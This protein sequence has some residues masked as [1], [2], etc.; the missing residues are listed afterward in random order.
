MV[1]V[2]CWYVLVVIWRC[3]FEFWLVVVFS[4]VVNF[5]CFVVSE[6]VLDGGLF[7][8]EKLNFLVVG[9]V[10]EFIG[11]VLGFLGLF[12]LVI[13]RFGVFVFLVW[14]W[15][16]GLWLRGMVMKIML[17]FF[18]F[19]IFEVFVMMLWVLVYFLFGVI[20]NLKLVFFLDWGLFSCCRMF[21]L[22][23]FCIVLCVV[24]MV[25]MLFDIVDIQVVV[26]WK[27]FLGILLCVCLRF[28]LMIE[29]MWYLV[30]VMLGFSI[31]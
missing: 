5:C 17:W 30:V 23:R 31:I 16:W 18:I 27:L 9:L 13:C 2:I 14:C 26:V 1:L 21:F 22:V 6:S 25:I 4:L 12:G 24:L 20:M 7:S 11:F 19:L 8:L 28:F 15:E 3:F 10:L 29:Q